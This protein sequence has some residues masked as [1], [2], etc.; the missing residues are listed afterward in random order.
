METNREKEVRDT[1]LRRR[2]CRSFS[3]T[4]IPRKDL[5]ELVEAGVYAPSAS[6]WQ[7]QRFLV[8]DDKTEIQRI[9]R[10]RFVWPWPGNQKAMREKEPG[11]LLGRASALIIVFV[12]AKRNDRRRNGEYHIWQHVE[13]QNAAASIQ[14]ILL[15]AAAK[16]IGSC[17]VSASEP[18]SYSRMLTGSAW[19]KTLA[20][21]NLPRSYKIQGI[22]VLGYPKRKD[23]LGF[24]SGESMHGA[25]IW[26]DTQR[27]ELESYLVT[28]AGDTTKSD[29]ALWRIY[30][31]KVFSGLLKVQLLG[32]KVTDM[33]LWFLEIGKRDQH[34]QTKRSS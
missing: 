2:S 8:V 18:M 30:I 25:T 20:K 1:I 28:E 4:P 31:A 7:N 14:N 33:I 24:P 32:V 26:Q 22:V 23:D 17:W 9:G 29:V 12:D 3:E 34:R 6:N 5:L 27:K 15:L 19:W 13:A 16:G 11:G 10:D 21:Y